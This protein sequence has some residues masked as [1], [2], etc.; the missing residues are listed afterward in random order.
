MNKSTESLQNQ[1]KPAVSIVI[2]VFNDEQFIARALNTA[3]HQTLKNIEIICVDDYSTDNTVQIIQSYVDKDS[4]IRLNRHKKNL[5]AFQARRNGIEAAKSLHIMFLDGDDEL[6]KDAA[7]L[8]LKQSLGTH[9]DMVGFGS[10][11]VRQ[12]GSSSREFEKS[13]QPTHSK[14][15]GNSI[16]AKLF[17]PGLPAQGSMWRYLFTK[18]LL[19][20][21]YGYFEKNQSIYRTNDLPISFLCAS[22][23]KK[24]TSIPDKLYVYH[25]YAGGS[26]GA[27]FDLDKFKF[28][29]KAIDSLN[30]L[31]TIVKKKDFN[32]IVRSSYD[33]ARIFVV[34]NIIRQIVNNLPAQ[35]YKQAVQ[36]LMKKASLDDV[37]YAMA[38]YIPESLDI[39]RENLDLNTKTRQSKNIALYTNNL[40]TGGVQS[41]VVSQAKYLEKAGFKV[42]I[43]VLKDE[44][45]VFNIPK[46]IKVERVLNGPLYRR[47]MSF[48]SILEKN[49]I[50]T[51]ID[52][53]ILYNYSW[54]FFNLTAKSLNIKSVAWIHSFALRPMTEGN[55]IGKFLN[56]NI[57]LI[58]DLVVLS[59]PDVSYW[60]SVGHSSVY[61]LP[62]PPSPLLT[63]NSEL[64]DVKKAPTKHLNII[65][66][67]RLQEATKKV[68]SLVDVAK[69]LRK[70][71]D[72]FT[73][74]I[75]GPGSNDLG[76]EDVKER[77]A[78]NGLAD[79]VEVVGPKHG[80]ELIK[81]IK[82]ADLYVCTSIIEGYQLT[83]I[84]AQSYGLPVVMYEL[85][86][87]AAVENNKGVI[88]TPQKNPQLAAQEI[89]NLFSNEDAYQQASAASLK[90]S[91]SY[92]SHDFS[93]LYTQ[94]LNHT[95]PSEF[96]PKVDV[97]HMSIFTLWTQYYLTELLESKSFTNNTD[98]VKRKDAEIRAL[99]NSKAMKL[100]NTLARPV[101]TAKEIKHKIIKRIKNHI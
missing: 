18:K 48:K 77:V 83:L 36:F 24:Y 13:I 56:E 27:D 5:S 54:P 21:A 23:A 2:P 94:L 76:I 63:E 70:L 51:V 81:E 93:K 97:K 19:L 28:Y 7:R 30:L 66:F 101:R 64:I 74:R 68:Y 58:D 60:K 42:T 16:I 71:T 40:Q 59:K 32:D 79:H 88:Q 65:W 20:K 89:L 84:E 100:G 25:F 43:I 46:S 61:Y 72:D 15:D 35:Y 4:R 99:K 87:L 50:D 11:I 31:G 98:V 53:N 10:K 1:N 49:K 75:V 12:D 73:L 69:E 90:A 47:L 41:V 3:T 29:T 34:S 45:I 38:S 95:L 57:G 67:G 14:L 91:K 86:W 96:S 44:N 6:H 92:L 17:E 39:I 26:G 9:S 52:H 22:L 78:Q 62:N 85:P 37:T 33:N 55:T 80:V 8:S 82:H